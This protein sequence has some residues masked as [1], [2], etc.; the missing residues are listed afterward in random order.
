LILFLVVSSAAWVAFVIGGTFLVGRS[1]LLRGPAFLQNILASLL[2]LPVGV[3]V[4]VVAATMLEKHALRFKAQRAG[5][6]LANCVSH[7]MFMFVLVLQRE[8]GVEIDLNGPTD[9][10]FAQRAMDAAVKKFSGD[11]YQTPLPS[12]FGEKLDGTV[13]AMA[14]CFRRS[15]DLH[16]AFPHAFDLMFDLEH[17]M[18]SIKKDERSSGPHNTTVILLNFATRILRDLR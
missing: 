6:E 16:L 1:D 9:D 15:A 8:C 12:D 5:D 13:A 10:R 2:V 3:A 7:S 18:K 14:E 4:A 17:L 11:S